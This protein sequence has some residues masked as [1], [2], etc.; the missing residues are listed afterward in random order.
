MSTPE[1]ARAFVTRVAEAFGVRYDGAAMTDAE[2]VALRAA[3]RAQRRVTRE[4]GTQH[5]MRNGRNRAPVRNCE[6]S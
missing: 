2:R 6:P 4:P 1:S 3:R 5:R